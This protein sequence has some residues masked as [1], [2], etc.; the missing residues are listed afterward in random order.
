LRVEYINPFVQAAFSVLKMTANTE[1]SRGELSLKGKAFL[2]QDITVAAGVVG[3]VEGTVFYS[4]DTGVALAIAGAM[5]GGGPLP[6]FDELAR[7]AIAELSNMIT[8]NAATL[9]AESGL[10]C[11]ISPPTVIEGRELRGTTVERTLCIP[12][13]TDQGQMDIVVG[14]EESKG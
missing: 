12:V 3:N 1:V 8:G 10:P 7:S 6:E 13:I 14:L 2:T 4:M 9:L 11:D 5:M